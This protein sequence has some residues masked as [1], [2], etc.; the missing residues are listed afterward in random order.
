MPFWN[1]PTGQTFSSKKKW[2]PKQRPGPGYVDEDDI[3]QPLQDASAEPEVAEA[4]ELGRESS[5]DAMG[6]NLGLQGA[7]PLFMEDEEE[8]DEDVIFGYLASIL[9]EAVAEEGFFEAA[10]N[11]EGI[12]VEQPQDMHESLDGGIGEPPPQPDVQIGG[13]SSSTSAVA[14]PAQP[15]NTVP[16]EP[17]ASQ[18]DAPP[19]K[20]ARGRNL[21]RQD[22]GVGFLLINESGGTI[23]GH[24]EL[25]GLRINRKRKPFERARSAKTKAQGRP[26]GLLLA[27]LEDCPG[28]ED[29]H[30]S[31]V[32]E[33]P[34]ERRRQM[35]V[36]NISNPL[37]KLFFSMLRSGN[38]GMATLMAS[39]ATYLE[40]DRQYVTM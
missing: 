40:H 13:S 6:S 9:D 28:T 11:D 24:C 31:L 21:C 3:P 15:A 27:M 8:E 10:E 36:D 26:V 2:V 20:K 4:S 18:S 19:N 35:R 33:M 23:D 7:A 37:L 17:P 22:F 1:G 32:A 39:L 34:F 30:R 25:C 5:S 29:K 38:P 12:E 14:L 16:A